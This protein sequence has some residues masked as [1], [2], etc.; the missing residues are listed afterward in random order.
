M[1]K[2]VLI[3]LLITLLTRGIMFISYPFGGEDD[4]QAAQNYLIN[5]LVHGNLLIGNLR[6]N[7]GYPL[8]IAPVTW[9]AQPLGRFDDRLVLL[10]QVTLAST[11]PF[12][13]YD[14]LRKR[15][16]ESEAF[17]V[18]LVV[19]L[20]PFGW[21][22]AHLTLP[23]W[24]VAFCVTLALWMIHRGLLSQQ[25]R[26]RWV[27]GAGFVMGIAVLAR[28]N[29]A[30]VVAVLGLG[31]FALRHLSLRQR[32]AMFIT[33]GATSGAML[34]AYIVLIHFPSTG[35][36]TLSCVSG[37][38]LLQSLSSKGVPLTPANGSMTQKYFELVTLEPRDIPLLSDTY[39]L[40]QKGDS[41]VSSEE[42]TRFLAQTPG[43]IA[44]T[45]PSAFPGT[46][47]KYLGPCATDQLLRSVAVEGLRTRPLQW[48]GGILPQVGQMLLYQPQPG[49]KNLYLPDVR[50]MM[51]VGQN[52][53]GFQQAEEGYYNGQIVWVPGIWLYSRIIGLVL[54]FGWLTLFAAAWA[55]LNRDWFYAT[56]CVLTLTFLA[57]IAVFAHPEPRYYANVYPFSGLILGG[58]LYAGFR[59]VRDRVRASG[60][61]PP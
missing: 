30:P 56:A 54:I 19:A 39:P 29:F 26:L 35:T 1:R 49:F 11:I 55:L 20:N 51:F 47:F 2:H 40:W 27:F 33:L 23:V 25:H 5:E 58:F 8:V 6:F 21:Q 15:R 16:S 44:E 32:L 18:A 3:L 42:L 17:F 24:L 60:A 10:V 43:P 52:R 4:N 41:W 50:D 22:W 45:L 36:W 7:T 31:F 9:L 14:I 59:W 61:A 57:L 34:L 12:L 13:I 48:A 38:N 53:V 37:A 46:L 28:F